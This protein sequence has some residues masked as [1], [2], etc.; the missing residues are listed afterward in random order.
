MANQPLLFNPDL[1]PIRYI[2]GSST[3]EFTL[4]G[5]F[6]TFWLSQKQ[7]AELFNLTQPSISN[8][9]KKFKEDRPEDIKSVHRKF[10]YTAVDGKTYDVDHYSHEVVIYI[11]YRAQATTET[12]RFQRFIEEIFRQRLEAARAMLRTMRGGRRESG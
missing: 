7:I 3:L 12:I 11:G 4:D 8:H 1:E 10:E 6:K 2:V 9:I 5:K